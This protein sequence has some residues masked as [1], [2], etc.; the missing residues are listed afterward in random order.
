MLETLCTQHSQ[1]F[2]C[3]RFWRWIRKLFQNG[4]QQSIGQDILQTSYKLAHGNAEYSAKSRCV[5]LDQNLTCSTFYTVCWIS[6]FCHNHRLYSNI[7]NFY[8]NK[9][10][11]RCSPPVYFNLANPYCI[12]VSLF[13]A[14]P[15]SCIKSVSRNSCCSP[16]TCDS[17]DHAVWKHNIS[18]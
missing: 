2:L 14:P 12:Y 13:W 9:K 5:S 18:N 10:C 11:M 15:T 6:M 3:T 8:L 16:Q 4:W 17:H 7:S 1:L